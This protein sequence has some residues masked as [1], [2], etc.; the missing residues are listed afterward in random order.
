MSNP[1]ND[2]ICIGGA[3][4]D[5]FVKSELS[6]ITR[7]TDLFSEMSLLCYP[8][9]SKV[10]VEE[11]FFDIGGGAVNTS[12]NFA[13]LGFK[14]S[15]V[16]KI[17]DDYSGDNILKT[18]KKSDINT[19]LVRVSKDF[20][21]GLSVILNSYEGDRTVLAY[22]GA[23]TRMRL[24]ELQ[25]DKLKETKWMYISSLSGDSNNILED[26]TRFACENNIHIAFNPGSTQIKRG[27]DHLKKILARIR[28]L[29]LNKEEASLFTGIKESYRHVDQDKCTGCGI[30]EQ[31][32]PAEIFEVENGKAT[33]AGRREDCIKGCNECVRHCP[34]VAI[35]V[36]PWATNMD[37]ILKKLYSYGPEIVVITDGSKGVQA[38]DG[39]N[40]YLL[41]TF[42]VQ[43]KSTLGA[44]DAF[45][46]TFTASMLK[47]AKDDN[48]LADRI[49][50][51]L[52]YA[53]AN[54]ACVVR[55]FGAQIG[56]ETFENLDAFIKDQPS[57]KVQRSAL[58]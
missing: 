5:I 43:V 30:C 11:V 12:V 57:V 9:G 16:I 4:Q 51:S 20:R 46:S 19:D 37:E 17:G 26:V 23:N 55:K 18:L 35:N 58:S 1:K 6:K 13:N 56:L 14:S 53:A 36:S 15:V 24:G 7:I 31:I 41:P 45:A 33:H 48:A 47:S 40:R 42:Q 27:A 21:T 2:I 44:G 28:Y 49:E 39:K 32:C 25:W 34:E 10:N 22:R 8:Y 3:T 54:S 52:L 29:I 38:Y 50:Q